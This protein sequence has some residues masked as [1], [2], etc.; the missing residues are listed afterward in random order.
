ML[1]CETFMLKVVVLKKKKTSLALGLKSIEAESNDSQKSV[2]L[3][4]AWISL[5]LEDGVNGKKNK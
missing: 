2:E 4:Q 5:Q 3:T 1:G